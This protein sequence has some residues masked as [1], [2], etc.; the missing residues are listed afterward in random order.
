MNHILSL[1][2]YGGRIHI[3]TEIVR[4]VD[5][6]E[7]D[8]LFDPRQSYHGKVIS[9]VDNRASVKWFKWDPAIEMPML[10]N[11]YFNSNKVVSRIKMDPD[12]ID[13][14]ELMH[15]LDLSRYEIGGPYN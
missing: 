11:L 4:T 7:G 2:K 12:E 8:M 5:L 3:D 10:E 9:V 6:R 1:G 13:T 14:E 15:K